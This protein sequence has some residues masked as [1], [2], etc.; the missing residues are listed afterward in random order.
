MRGRDDIAGFIA[1]FTGDDGYIVDYLVE[2]V[3]QRQPDHVCS[4]LLATSIPGPTQRAPLQGASPARALGWG[5][6]IHVCAFEEGHQTRQ[7]SDRRGAR[8]P[9]AWSK[10]A[11]AVW[12]DRAIMG[13]G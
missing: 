13:L 5:E 3:L 12:G 8:R 9:E 6:D 2:E 10:R 4:F 7:T 11:P 1:G